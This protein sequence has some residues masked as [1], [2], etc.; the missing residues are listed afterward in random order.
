MERW[1]NVVGSPA[2]VRWAIL[3]L[4]L[5]SLVLG[6]MRAG[7]AGGQTPPARPGPG[8]V[9]LALG[10]SLAVGVGAT[11]PAQRGFVG[12]LHDW[13]VR[14]TP[15]QPIVARNLAVSGETSQS[16]VAGGQLTRALDHLRVARQDGR[17][18]S[19][20]LLSI[21]G[22]DLLQAERAAPA[23]RR[24]ALE[25]FKGNL[26]Q[27]LDQVGA[28]LTVDGQRQGALVIMTVYNP[29]G[30][31]TAATGSDAWWVEQFNSVLRDEAAARDLVLVDTWALMAGKEAAWTY[32][33]VGDV[34]PN[35]AGHLAIAGAIWQA[36]GYDRSPPV[37]EIVAPAAG[38]AA[39][40]VPTVRARVSDN[41]GVT[42][43]ELWVAGGRVK[44]LVWLPEYGVYVGTWDARILAP[45]AYSLEVRAFDAAGV[46]GQSSV[47]VRLR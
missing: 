14:L 38:E 10:D 16:F 31:D 29:R 12:V 25:R 44:E 41:V 30:G 20:V 8:A 43:V 28:E 24:Q 35:N 1:S 45:G 32:I 21:G 36:L 6:G 2:R 4:L 18:V 40:R 11:A 7:A 42:R 23:A 15:S 5:T 46:A 22:N 9:F 47:E 19:P 17:A 34:H 13:L 3:L 33:S 26:S 39:R 37:V 27:I